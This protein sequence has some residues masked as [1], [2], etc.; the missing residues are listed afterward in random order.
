[1]EASIS[2]TNFVFLYILHK[3]VTVIVKFVNNHPSFDYL[4]CELFFYNHL[5]TS[6][7][8]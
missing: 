4:S 6:I 2:L 1:M 5:T 7:L 3:V 8:N